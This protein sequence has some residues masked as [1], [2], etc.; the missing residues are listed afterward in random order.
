MSLNLKRTTVRGCLVEDPRNLPEKNERLT[1][2]RRSHDFACEGSLNRCCLVYSLKPSLCLSNIKMIS[3][4]LKYMHARIHWFC[5]S[6]ASNF[7]GLA[8]ANYLPEELRSGRFN[9][10]SGTNQTRCCNRPAS[11]WPGKFLSGQQPNSPIKADTS[12]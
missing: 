9:Y 2:T 6:Q 4:N 3:N 11:L 10:C 5:L 12:R 1:G 7:D 8:P